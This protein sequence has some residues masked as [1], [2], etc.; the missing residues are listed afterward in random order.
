MLS[1]YMPTPKNPIM[2]KRQRKGFSL[3]EIILSICVLA[4]LT[5]LA[6]VYL[7]PN[8][9]VVTNTRL[10]SD[11]LKLNQQISVY[12]AQGGS[13]DNISTAQDVIN[14]LKTSL[15]PEQAKTQVGTMTGRSVDIRLAARA[16][17][18]QQ[19]NSG[20][21]MAVWNATTKRFEIKTSSLPSNA[22]SEFY[23]NDALASNDYGTATVTGTN[24]NYNAE[25]GWVWAADNVN[26]QG[27]PRSPEIAMI[28][29]ENALDAGISTT[30]TNS[31]TTG[32]A[33]TASSTTSSAT[34]SSSTTS[35][36]TT[37]GSTTS[38]STTASSTTS[39]STTGAVTA[40]PL[41]TPVINPKGG[42]FFDAML[43]DKAYIN[44]NGAPAGVSVIKYRLNSGDWQ[45]YT[46][47][48]NITAGARIEAKAFSTSEYYTDSGTRLERYYALTP[49]FTGL[50]SARWNPSNGPS[51]MVHSIDNSNPNSVV[52]LDG[53]AHI[54][55]GNGRNSFTF[56]RSPSFTNVAPDADFVLGQI[57]YKN[58]TIN[59]GTGATNLNLR[60]DITMSNPGVAST[61][62]D[63]R[64]KL[65]NTVN[66]AVSEEEDADY[67]ILSNPVTNYAINVGGVTYTL[68]VRYGTI[69]ASQG[70]VNGYTLGVWEGATGTVDIIARFVSSTPD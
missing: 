51:T 11:V 66:N 12:L 46:T 14:K 55:S 10:E 69:A 8:I 2:H 27:N 49:A 70:Y 62:A 42:I 21:P 41:P 45:V 57:T 59:S 6:V 48:I 37:R 23:L 38:S 35:S 29:S 52:E 34:T 47:P 65:E 20:T 18:S 15:T 36:S 39:G 67:C 9:N 32:A 17:T 13:L 31:S 19:R 25:A 53:I 33:T 68:T 50:V 7:T 26:P 43:P 40:I 1:L 63:I 44:S 61:P 3:V 4:V 16:A 28:P 64:I 58:G 56:R 30:T 5:T 22:V 60:L 54:S 24:V